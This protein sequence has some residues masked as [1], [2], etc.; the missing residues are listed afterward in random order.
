MFKR[1]YS[2]FAVILSGAQRSRRTSSQ[3]LPRD[4]STSLGMTEH[5]DHFHRTFRQRFQEGTAI[6]ARHDAII[7]DHDDSPIALRPNEAA[8][9]LTEFQDRLGQRIFGE[10]VAARRLYEFQFRFD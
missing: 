5:S 4:P 8:H 10:G 1:S 2:N 7:K 6:R 9:A 3:V